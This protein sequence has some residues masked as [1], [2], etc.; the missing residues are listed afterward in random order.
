MRYNLFLII[1]YNI[2]SLLK[3]TLNVLLFTCQKKK[4]LIL[5]VLL[6]YN[7]FVTSFSLL[8]IDHK[9]CHND[10]R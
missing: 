2:K 9:L 8:S 10:I 1:K 7:I 6:I 3:K 4:I 5:R